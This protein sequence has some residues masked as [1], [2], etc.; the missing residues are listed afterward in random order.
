M[1]Q[2]IRRA[3]WKVG[4]WSVVLAVFIVMFFGGGGPGGFAHDKGRIVAVAILFIAGYVSFFIMMSLTRTRKGE[5][6]LS[7]D[8]RD[9]RLESKAGGAT[10]TFTLVYVYALSIAL[11]AYFQKSGQVPAGWLWFLAYSSVF[12]AMLTHGIFTLLFA[13]CRLGDGES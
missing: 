8:E 13:A 4:I 7:R 3:A 6:G 5:Q 9:D 11:W 1:T 10:L 2:S 12:L